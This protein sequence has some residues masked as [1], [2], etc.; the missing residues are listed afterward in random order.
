MN[1]LDIME[2]T[3]VNGRDAPVDQIVEAANAAFTR[4]ESHRKLFWRD[5]LPFLDGV[6]HLSLQAWERAGRRTRLDGSPDWTEDRVQ[7]E[8]RRLTAALPWAHFFDGRRR[9][10]LSVLHQIGGDREDFLKWYDDLSEEVRERTGYP[11]KLW[12]M[13]KNEKKKPDPDPDDD[14]NNEQDAATTNGSTNDSANDSA[15][16]PGTAGGA[17][18]QPTDQGIRTDDDRMAELVA[19]NERWHD[20][21]LEL[22]TSVD[23]GESTLKAGLREKLDRLLEGAA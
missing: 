13:F 21:G 15:T 14:H 5:W 6:Y 12:R 22:R 11:E 8:F 19:K 2:L 17:A 1:L 7:V 20:F 4:I 23:N 10:L 16:E 18:A 9:T 3:S